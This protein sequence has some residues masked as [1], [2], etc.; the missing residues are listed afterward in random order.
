MAG[1][2]LSEVYV[3]MGGRKSNY[4]RWYR[5]VLRDAVEGV[6][7]EEFSIQRR[8]SGK[9]GYKGYVKDAILSESFSKVLLKYYGFRS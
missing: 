8:I 3:K 7:Y 4:S 5:R 6:D 9:V 1:V 2:V